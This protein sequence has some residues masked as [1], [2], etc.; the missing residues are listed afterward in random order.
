MI[1][2]QNN[3]DLDAII[4]DEMSEGPNENDPILVDDANE[5]DESDQDDN[6]TTAWQ[7]VDE[8][9]QPQWLPQYNQQ[10]GVTANFPQNTT[11]IVHY[12]SLFYDEEVLDLLVQE[13]NRYA[14]QYF[15]DR[16][17][18]RSNVYYSGW[19]HCDR[20]KIKAYLG[21]IIHMGLSQ[22]PRMDYHW[23][24]TPLYSCSLCP[25][26]MSKRDFFL[27]HG[28]LHFADNRSANLDDKIYKGRKLFDLLTLRFQRYYT[29]H[30]ELTIDERIVKF[31]G[32]LSFLQYIRNK[33]N[34]YGI[35]V[36]V[37]ADAHNGYV[38]SWKVYT[39]AERRE[40]NA[41]ERKNNIEDSKPKIFKTIVELT[42]NFVNLGHVICFDSYYSYLEV[43]KHLARR[44][45]GCIG[46]LNKQR[47][48]L[49]NIIKNPTGMETGQT[50]FR[51]TNNIMTLVYK[52]KNYVRLF[53]NVHGRE[54][55][56]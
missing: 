13:T 22:Y 45:F 10:V 29:P 39:G 24:K 54:F 34:Q 51:R 49:P 52:D 20:A 44:N 35:K 26:I 8:D 32:R 53:S 38:C 19:A 11:T 42:N 50:I 1:N 23:A 28:F 47:K 12:F 9:W 25:S 33:P 16:P 46:T 37:L 14:D 55:E 4:Q 43:I 48:F 36:F 18:Q 56:N 40:N 5:T 21:M 2:S 17:N 3:H 30:R 41:E 6:S 15:Q 7:E 27:L 31:S